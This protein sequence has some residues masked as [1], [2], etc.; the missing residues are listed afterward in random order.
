MG[1]L[2]SLPAGIVTHESYRRQK[3]YDLQWTSNAHAQIFQ[4][5]RVKTVE[6]RGL[7]EALAGTTVASGITNSMNTIAKDYTVNQ[8]EHWRAYLVDAYGVLTER[9]LVIANEAG[10]YTVSV[11]T[12]WVQAQVYWNGTLLETF[13]SLSS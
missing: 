13:G 3:V 1:W 2:S 8:D 10:G 5:I 12:T 7:T 11:T 9:T 6:Y 4:N